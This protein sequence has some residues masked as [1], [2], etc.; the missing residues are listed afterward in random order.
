MRQ[1]WRERMDE[2]PKLAGSIAGRAVTAGYV[3][4]SG[5]PAGKPDAELLDLLSVEDFL[6]V[7]GIEASMLEGLKPD[8]VAALLSLR[9]IDVEALDQDELAALVGTARR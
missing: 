3:V 7:C 5:A 9:G 4:E 8:A 2:I 1:K 6:A